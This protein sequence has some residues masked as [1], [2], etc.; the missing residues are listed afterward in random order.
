MKKLNIEEYNELYDLVESYCHTT[1]DYRKKERIRN[2]IAIFLECDI[3]DAI[4]LIDRHY[5]EM[6]DQISKPIKDEIKQ[7]FKYCFN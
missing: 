6:Y 2:D 5:P 1:W 3:N 4:T 7:S